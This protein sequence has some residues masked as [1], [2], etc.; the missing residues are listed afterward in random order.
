MG[1]LGALAAGSLDAAAEAEAV[2]LAD[3]EADAVG[4]G[5]ACWTTSSM[6]D[7]APT[8]TSPRA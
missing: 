7:G 8:L 3:A 6:A 2:A 5:S 4:C 1:G